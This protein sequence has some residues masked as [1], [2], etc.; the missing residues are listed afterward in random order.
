MEKQHITRDAAVEY[1]HTV[2]AERTRWTKFLYGVDWTDPTLYD[3][4]VNAERMSLDTA[5]EMIAQAAA[6]SEFAITEAVNRGL[7]D[8]WLG[9]RVKLALASNVQTRAID[10]EV[11]AVGGT[12]EIFGEMPTAGMLT[13]ASSRSEAEVT[14][15]VQSVPGVQ[16]VLLSVK[17]VD[18]YH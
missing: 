16:K 6:R 17:K 2:D 10:F 13:H 8:F 5:C 9:C 4:M 12:V 18:A 1:I 14:E 7:T 3:V 15:V 11:R